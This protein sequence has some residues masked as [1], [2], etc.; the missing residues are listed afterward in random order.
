MSLRYYMPADTTAGAVGADRLAA[1]IADHIDR[2]CPGAELVR[3]GSRGAFWLE[4]LLEIERDGERVGFGPLA[5]DELQEILA[6]A[7]GDWPSHPRYL[8]PVDALPWFA[9]QQ[10]VTFARAG[11]GDPLCLEQYLGAVFRGKSQTDSPVAEQGTADL[12]PGVFQGE[13]QVPGGRSC[14]IGELAFHP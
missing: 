10:R 12:R 9:A 6:L 5:A 3:N 4:P 1:M 13:I 11:L 7:A 2:Q 8:G 14:Q